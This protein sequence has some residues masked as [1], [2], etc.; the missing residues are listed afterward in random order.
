MT[1][2]KLQRWQE[3][4]L[5]DAS[6]TIEQWLRKDK[7]LHHLHVKRRG[8]TLTLHNADDDHARLTLVG[9]DVW[10]LS[11]PRHTGRWE[12]TPFLG[13]LDDVYDTLT[14]MLGFHLAER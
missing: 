3:D 10:G 12:K 5:E 4:Q 1:T 7:A 6:V 9:R 14:G 11:L 13:A 2:K 8:I